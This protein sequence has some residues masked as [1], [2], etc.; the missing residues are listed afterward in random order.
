MTE[1]S[2]TSSRGWRDNQ[3]TNYASHRNSPQWQQNQKSFSFPYYL[4]NSLGNTYCFLL[5]Y[6][7][8]LDRLPNS[9]LSWLVAL[10]IICI[11]ALLPTPRQILR[12]ARKPF[13]RRYETIGDSDEA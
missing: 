1:K 4:A 7:G 6:F 12:F 10:A 11:V 9:V 2:R 3:R 8:S 13:V 5:G